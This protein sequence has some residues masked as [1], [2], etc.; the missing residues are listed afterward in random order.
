MLTTL[1]NHS[2]SWL[3]KL[4]LGAIVLTFVV[5]FGIGTFSGTKEVL[6]KVGG[7]EILVRDFN[8]LYQEDLDRL[9]RRFP[10]NADSMAQQMNLRR[11]VF[12]RMINRRLIL[13]EAREQGFAITN[14]EIEDDIKSETI[15]QIDGRFDFATYRTVLQQNGR[16]PEQYEFR[17][18]EDLLLQKYQ[19]NLLAAITVSTA[20]VEQRF[21][22]ENEQVQVDFVFFDPAHYESTVQVTAEDE[23]NYHNSHLAEFMQPEQFQVK[24]LILAMDHVL[25]T[26]KLPSKAVRRYYDRYKEDRF[27]TPKRVRASHILK[28]MDPELDDDAKIS[29]RQQMEIVLIQ[30][31]RGGDFAEL[32]R[33][34]SED[35]TK[36][37]GGDLGFFSQGEMVA[38]FEEAAFALE[39]GEISGI[40]ESP[41]GLHIIKVTEV[42]AGAESSFEEVEAQIEELLKEQ[43]TERKLD[44]EANRL[45]QKIQET[46]LEQVAASLSLEVKES[47]WFDGTTTLDVLGNAAPLYDQ[48]RTMAIGDAG[49]WRRNPVLGHVFYQITGK[50]EAFTLPVE[51]VRLQAREKLI[52]QGSR[53]SATDA[54]QAALGEMSQPSDLQKFA[55]KENFAVRSAEIDAMNAEIPGIG[56]NPNFQR[57]AFRLTDEAPFGLSS[58]IG[59]NYLLRL[60]NR[61]IPESLDHKLAKEALLRNLKNEWNQYFMQ[62]E[63]ERLRSL[64]EIEIVAP[65]YLVGL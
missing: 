8:R 35:K 12:E 37:Q 29:I 40:V 60:V 6:V 32:A 30:L 1:R 63:Y 18:R 17:L 49:V 46:G 10:D 45:P 56:V 58:G 15:F 47:D 64:V 51:Q 25:P 39:P 42:E 16:N 13:A 62:K 55:E 34:H 11:Q 31:R 2:Q 41:F 19:R 52:V 59:E 44:L 36:D 7:E 33:A 38:N 43:R 54:A 48:M 5:S 61:A 28:R 27:S 9:R 22:M 50:K 23:E 53:K 26:V 20:E 57:T 65:E 4:L 3:I 14:G 21:L 24:Y